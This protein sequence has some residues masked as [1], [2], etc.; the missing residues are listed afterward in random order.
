MNTKLS[1]DERA[2][3]LEKE[4]TLDE[5]I[6]LVHGPMSMPIFG[7]KKP[8]G[9]IGS[10]GY[11]AGIERLGVPALQESD[12][13]LGVTNPLGVRPGDGA[14]AC[15]R[16]LLAATFNTKL[17]YEAEPWSAARRGPRA[18]TSSSPAA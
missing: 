3:L 5:R 18:S 12:A 16:V 2:A 4:L 13:S 11:I 6:G 1:P 14:T 9:A 10:A 17:A 15:R 7:I 8:E